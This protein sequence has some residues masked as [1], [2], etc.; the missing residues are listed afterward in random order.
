MSEPQKFATLQVSVIN[1]RGPSADNSLTCS[2]R[3]F[4]GSAELRGYILLV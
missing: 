1:E 2:A 4:C 3:A